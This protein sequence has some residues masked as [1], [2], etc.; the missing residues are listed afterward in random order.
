MCMLLVTMY[1]NRLFCSSPVS[2][3]K[4]GSEQ[5][6]TAQC[7]DMSTHTGFSIN[8]L[9]YLTLV[10]HVIRGFTLATLP[11][12]LNVGTKMLQIY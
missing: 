2:G 8:S 5:S 3:L 9:I 11:N 6:N 1:S 10:K 12:S 4:F 7:C